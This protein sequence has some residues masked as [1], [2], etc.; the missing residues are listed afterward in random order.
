MGESKNAQPKPVELEPSL[1]NILYALTIEHYDEAA[2]IVDALE[3]YREHQ[4]AELD[5]PQD[6]RNR[7]ASANLIEATAL[8]DAFEDA[9]RQ[10]TL[11]NMT[12][13]MRE[14]MLSE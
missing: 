14:Y 1:A 8:V 7:W 9:N 4:L 2:M 11:D 12:P 13:K 3:L 5:K 10:V 6:H